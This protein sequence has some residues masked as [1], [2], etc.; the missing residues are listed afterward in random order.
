VGRAMIRA[1][2]DG[3]PKQVLEAK[4]IGELAPKA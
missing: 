2:K 3:A 1:V 4:D